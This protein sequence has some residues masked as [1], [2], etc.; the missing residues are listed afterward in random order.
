MS[1][2]IDST[3]KVIARDGFDKATTRNIAGECGIPDAY[4]YSYFKDK[5]E[6]FA[7]AFEEIDASLHIRVK[8]TLAAVRLSGVSLETYLPVVLASFWKYLISYPEL[9]RFYVQYYYSPY[10]SKY[11]AASHLKT[12]QLLLEKSADEFRTGTDVRAVLRLTL[13]TALGLAIKTLNDGKQDDEK[14]A[15]DCFEMIYNIVKPWLKETTEE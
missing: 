1:D 10:Y 6:L 11:S 9:C 4:I 8:Q 5:E 2:L 12:W 15:R 13:N 14:T 7:R 3:V